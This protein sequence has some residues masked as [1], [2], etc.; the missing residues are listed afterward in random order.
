MNFLFHMLLSGDDDQLLVGNF[1]GDFVKGPLQGR[2]P[3]RIRQGVDLHRHIDSYAEHHPLF[4]RSRGR[5]D[6]A[7]GLYRGILVD[8]FYDHLL[9]NDWGHWSEEPFADFLLRTRRV[10]ESYRHVIPEAML[11]LLPVI[12]DE[13]LPSYGTVGGIARALARL[14]RRVGRPNPLAG[15]AEELVR[16]R[17]DLQDDFDIFTTEIIR[18]ASRLRGDA[19]LSQD[20]SVGSPLS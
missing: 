7:Y 9:V 16:L 2:F 14:S 13:L 8:M 5:I 4:R 20:G 11:P 19:E 12:F 17:G 10:V 3:E 15:G 18:H 6:P 1:M